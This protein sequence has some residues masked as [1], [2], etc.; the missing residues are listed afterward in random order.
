MDAT[1]SF[2]RVFLW[3]ASKHLRDAL[4][5]LGNV[6]CAEDTTGSKGSKVLALR[7]PTVYLRRQ[8]RRQGPCQG[9]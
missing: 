9:V 1:H 2:I 5:L 3:Y 4:C 8:T 6:P 7:K